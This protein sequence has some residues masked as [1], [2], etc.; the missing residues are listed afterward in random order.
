MHSQT[1]FDHPRW[2]RRTALEAGAISLLGLGIPELMALKALGATQGVSSAPRAC[3][4]I[5]LSGGLSQHDSFDMKPHTPDDIR[6]EFQPIATHTPGLQICE[7]L[8]RLAQRSAHWALCRSLTHSS[9]EHSAAHHIMLTGRTTLP[10]GFSPS[11]PG[12][13]D[14]PSIAAVAGVATKPRNNLP[15]AVVLPE[16]LLHSTGRVIPGQF[17]G[18]MGTSRDPWFIEASPF[19]NKSYG[20]FP[21]YQ[22]DHQERGDKDERA[23]RAPSLT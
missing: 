13:N 4:Y 9:N 7:H 8:P 2:S 12:P 3:I 5:F 6:G 11:G 17:A 15:P 19:H 23:F 14:E 16:K 21:Q 20:A 10:R 18:R 22:F 1:G